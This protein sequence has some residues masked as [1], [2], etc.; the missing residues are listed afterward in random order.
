MIQFVISKKKNGLCS[1]HNI[2]KPIEGRLADC[3]GQQPVDLRNRV[4][5]LWDNQNA[6]KLILKWINKYMD[7]SE[8]T[9]YKGY[10]SESSIDES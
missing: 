3:K 7:K 2:C 8:K 9:F 5:A 10:V 4:L 1:L 6:K